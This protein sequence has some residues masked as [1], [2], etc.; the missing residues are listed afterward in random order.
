M[1]RG[2][3]RENFGL[4]KVDV[5]KG[6]VGY[7]GFTYFT[8]LEFAQETYSGA[9]A[10]VANTDALII[11]L[12]RCGGS[13]SPDA[14][15]FV[16]SYLFAEPT[17]LS[18]IYWRTSD[19]VQQF[20]TL[21][22]V[23]GRRFVN[24]PVYIL[25]SAQT[26]SGAEGMAYDLQS[27]KRATVI[28]DVSGGGANPGG[29]WRVDDHFAVGVPVG[30]V[31]NPITKTNWEG[32]GVTPDVKVPAPLAL[33]AAHID[34]L[35]KLA[36]SEK[37]PALQEQLKAAIAEAEQ[38]KARWRKVSVSLKGYAAA[39]E[40]FVAG[41]FNQWSPRTTRLEREGDAWVGEILAEPGEHT[42]KFVVDDTWMT[43]PANPK[44]AR[45]GEFENS[46]L[47]VK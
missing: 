4:A 19:S 37:E 41:S 26:F 43:D 3:V 8:A 33:T 27:L 22:T 32:T 2:Q 45:D 21:P 1:R 38:A 11:D 24:K 47:V 16:C 40:V 7:I 5:L 34:A 13:M 18:E 30:R 17:R 31:T 25:T 35:T 12:R 23:P 20:W 9:M 29:S 14:L 42:Y 6:N 28:G 46:V 36:A 44:T 39:K 10:V 15:P